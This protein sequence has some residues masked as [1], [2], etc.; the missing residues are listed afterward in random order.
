MYVDLFVYHEDSLK[1]IPHQMCVIICKV[2]LTK[3]IPSVAYVRTVFPWEATNDTMYITGIPPHTTL[4][5][6]IESLQCIIQYFKVSITRDIKG[7]LKDNLD[8]REI[9]GLVFV[10]AKLIFSKLDEIIT[11]NN[12]TTNQST[13]ERGDCVL[14]IVEYRVSSEDEILIDLDK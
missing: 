8:A 1:I 7:L 3:K 11:H 13:G 5:Y 9:G 14:H 4:I 2:F 6:E 12:V 10:Q